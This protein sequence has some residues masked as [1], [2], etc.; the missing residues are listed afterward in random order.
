MSSLKASDVSVV[1]AA[2]N[3][4]RFIG[5]A[6]A[7]I[8]GQT[9]PPGEIIVV[10][11]GSTDGTAEIAE[12]FG[13]RLIRLEKNGGPE[14]ARNRGTEI[15]RG[16]WIAACDSDDRWLPTKLE[17]QLAFLNTWSGVRPIVALGTSGININESGM[18]QS[19]LPCPITTEEE[20][21]SRFEQCLPMMLP[22]SSVLYDREVTAKVGGYRLGWTPIYDCD[23]WGRMAEHGVVMGIPDELFEYR[24]RLSSE[25]QRNFWA[26]EVNWLRLTENARRKRTGQPELDYDD[27]VALLAERPWKERMRTRK[28]WIGHYA[29]R[30]GANRIVNGHRVSG[31]AHLGLASLLAPRRVLSGVSAKLGRSFNHH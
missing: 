11:D 27:M 9:T 24:K 14:T 2:Y 12:S 29:Y 6:L 25:Y 15:A 21:D 28:S 26:G 4:E 16:R 22:Y 10:D 18:P 3:D 5:Q 31:I 19:T 23:L 20:F 1:M 13:V 7:S 17:R 8:L 30:T